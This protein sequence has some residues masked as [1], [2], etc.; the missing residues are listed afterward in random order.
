ML[1]RGIICVSTQPS[2]S[3]RDTDLMQ[4]VE[5]LKKE[6]SLAH[7]IKIGSGASEICLGSHLT[8]RIFTKRLNFTCFVPTTQLRIELMLQT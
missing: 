3:T 1:L 7:T 5:V 4:L 2:T 6:L 8:L